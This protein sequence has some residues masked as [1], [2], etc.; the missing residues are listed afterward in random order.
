LW[1][2]V[3]ARAVARQRFRAPMLDVGCGH[4]RFARAIFG[5]NEAIAVGCDLLF[6]QLTA[7]RNSRTY[8]SVALADGHRLPHRSDAFSS[9]L[10]NSVLEHIPDPSNVLRE[11]SRVLRCGG[12]LVVTVPSNH[13]HDYLTTSQRRRV[14][15]QSDSAVT[16]TLDIDKQLQHYHYHMPQEWERLFQVA[17]LK[18][19]DK[20]YYMTPAAAAAWDRMNQKYGI[21]Q[22]SLFSVLVSPRLR[23]LGYQR[24]VAWVLPRLLDRRLR[25]YYKL[26]LKPN[27]TGA[28]LLLVAE[29]IS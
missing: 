21:G 4:G 9:I 27:E 23:W 20:T 8:S 15:G 25:R 18:L 22:R 12:R 3:E 11:L 29:K 24:F 2:A 28:G 14:S 19:V 13:F 17:G 6:H 7:A 1:R 10:T 26:E 16:N 5:A